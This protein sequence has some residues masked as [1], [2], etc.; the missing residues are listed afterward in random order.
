MNVLVNNVLVI[1]N[2]TQKTVGERLKAFAKTDRK[3]LETLIGVCAR[4]FFVDQICAFPTLG[5]SQLERDN[6]FYQINRLSSYLTTTCIDVLTGERYQPYDQWFENA[7]NK[8]TL[9]DSWKQ[10]ISELSQCVN[11]DDTA[12]KF[13]ELT[14]DLHKR[15]YKE[16][17]S[18][19]K[20]F[21]NFVSERD[22][23]LKKWLL[24]NYIVEEFNDR[25]RKCLGWKTPREQMAACLASALRQAG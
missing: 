13:L 8:G 10:A 24:E 7:Y 23:G 2:V 1:N 22:G 5:N 18:I 25:P 4:L 11:P 16:T 21:K 3:R 9:D 14:K 12:C 6:L 17:M 19:R 20:S 15:A